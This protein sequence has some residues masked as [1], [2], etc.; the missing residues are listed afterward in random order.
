MNGLDKILK[1]IESDAMKY[2]QSIIEEATK[3]AIENIKL[4][5]EKAN[6]EALSIK[7]ISQKQC[8]NIKENA[9]SSGE[10]LIRISLL[11]EKNRIIEQLI[12]NTIKIIP[13]DNEDEYFEILKSLIINN[14]HENEE[15]IILFTNKD[16]KRLPRNFLKEL[17]KEL[18]CK[19][20]SLKISDSCTDGDSGFIITYKDI[21]ENCILSYLLEEKKD[22]L[23]RRLSKILV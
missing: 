13:D 3:K 19:N 15:G 9:I 10:S 4:S 22:E 21:E 18:K 20:A 16:L 2:S 12:N 8:I 17:N 5:I 7:E 11:K 23:K 6:K 1:K 14:C